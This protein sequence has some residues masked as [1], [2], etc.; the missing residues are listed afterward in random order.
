MTTLSLA[1]LVAI[2]GD[3]SIQQLHA[4]ADP[5]R[6]VGGPCIFDPAEPANIARD[7]V[8]LAV[9][10]RPESVPAAILAAGTAGAAGVAVK[11]DFADD[12]EV[13]RAAEDT[14]LAVLVLAPSISWAQFFD[15]VKDAANAAGG[16][17]G[18]D[19]D[20]PIRDLFALANAVA[21]LVGGA[22]TIEDAN[23]N[24]LAYSTLDQPIDAPRMQTILGRQ[25]PERWAE[26]LREVGVFPQLLALP[27][28]VVH[29]EDP[30]GIARRRLATAIRAGGEVLGYLWAIEGGTPFGPQSESALME[31]T[32]V[33]ALQLLKHRASDDVSRRE[34][35]TL[36]RDL[37][38]GT[39]EVKAVAASLGVDAET[40]C[41]VVAFRLTVDDDVE[42]SMKR[43]RLVDM[44]TVVCEA[45]RRRVVIS[46]A[47]QSVYA[48]FPSLDTAGSARLAPL[49]KSIAEQSDHA[50]EGALVVGI[51][52]TVLGLRNAGVSKSEADRA[53]RVLSTA[54]S[55]D[56][57]VALIDDV[58]VASILL[59][60]S[61]L[62]RD[63][64][65]LHL[66]A[67]DLIAAHD[68]EHSK[69]YLPTLT[70]FVQS[71]FEVGAAAKRLDLHPNSV[72][73]RLKRIEE[74]SGLD[75]TDVNNLLVV[76]LHLVA[77]QRTPD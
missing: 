72:R 29:V 63:H 2:V 51:G 15:V 35:G 19:A 58:R 60:F 77:Q 75:L 38:E 73:Y 66:P 7:D 40:P 41:A 43:A 53:V 45:F 68:K 55:P 74:I 36:L 50:L 21:A 34:R 59:G 37:L 28:R 33:A 10:L 26:R 56:R 52:S 24:L 9:N 20:T 76:A 54:P 31:A 49:V 11:G 70:A 27:Q 6:V 32:P 22:V 71:A 8:V 64:D 57:K 30:E 44:I 25:L 69:A 48:L 61:D 42:L 5:S 23:S 65:D 4:P 1:S 16:V 14:G 67:L 3:A 17:P 39:R 12:Q 47:G 62:L 13:R 46:S 18:D